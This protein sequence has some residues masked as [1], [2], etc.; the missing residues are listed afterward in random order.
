M[1]LKADSYQ[2]NWYEYNVT[3]ILNGIESR[4][5]C[6]KRLLGNQSLILNGIERYKYDIQYLPIRLG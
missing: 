1:E 6:R 5:F 4:W 3:L 2:F